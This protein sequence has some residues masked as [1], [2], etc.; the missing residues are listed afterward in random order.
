MSG[1][2]LEITINTTTVLKAHVQNGTTWSALHEITLFADNNTSNIKIAEI[3][4]HPL[5]ADTI[6]DNEFEFPELKNI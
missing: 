6:S 3:H 1:N 2:E 5:D 4:Y